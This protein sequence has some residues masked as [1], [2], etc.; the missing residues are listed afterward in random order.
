MACPLYR[1]ARPEGIEPPIAGFEVRCLIRWA[2]GARV[3]ISV[4]SAGWRRRYFR[5]RGLSLQFVYASSALI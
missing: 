3:Q 1:M 5:K 4:K 2:T